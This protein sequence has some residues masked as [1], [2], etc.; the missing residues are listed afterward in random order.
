MFTFPAG[1]YY[2]GDPVFVMDADD[3]RM[4][5][6]EA[7]TPQGIQGGGKP[8]IKSVVNHVEGRRKNVS[9]WVAKTPSVSGTLYD[10]NGQAWGFDWGVFGCMDYE[11]SSH[12]GSYTLNRVEFPEPFICSYTDKSITI[13]HLHFTVNKT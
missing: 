3:L 13:G 10:Q 7:L 6:Q 12:Q 5:F 1:V 11:W 9:Y 4:L 8:L 2:V